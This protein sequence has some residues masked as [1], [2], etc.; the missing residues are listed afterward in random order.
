MA[1]QIGISPRFFETERGRM[2]DDWEIKFWRELIQNSVDADSTTI[3]IRI[4][5]LK[6][7]NGNTV[8]GP[9]MRP[10]CRVIFT[11]NGKGMDY[12][13][14]K[15]V[16]MMLG[17]SSKNSGD[18][19]GGFGRAR[20]LTNFS[21]QRYRIET[22]TWCVEGS[23]SAYEITPLDRTVKGCVQEIDVKG[24]DIETMRHALSRYLSFCQLDVKVLIEDP[25]S[26]EMKPW[27]IW[28]YRRGKTDQLVARN[29]AFADVHLVKGT[30][31]HAGLLI[32]RVNGVAMFEQPHAAKGRVIVEI[33]PDKASPREHK[34]LTLSRDSLHWPYRD[35]L[36]KLQSRLAINKSSALRENKKQSFVIK[37]GADTSGIFSVA[38]NPRKAAKPRGEQE[39]LVADGLSYSLD[40]YEAVTASNEGPA[41]AALK[42]V[43]STTLNTGSDT[44]P[45]GQSNS[46]LGTA[47]GDTPA[48]GASDVK[49]RDAAQGQSPD[50]WRTGELDIVIPRYDIPEP[51]DIDF[52]GESQAEEDACSQ[53]EGEVTVDRDATANGQVSSSSRGSGSSGAEDE[54]RGSGDVRAVGGSWA[55]AQVVRDDQDLSLEPDSVESGSAET[56]SDAA[57]P[58]TTRT[59]RAMRQP[60]P[61]NSALSFDL[62]INVDNPNPKIRRAMARFDPRRWSQPGG[63]LGGGHAAKLLTCWNV[64]VHHSAQAML[65]AIGGGALRYGVGLNFGGSAEALHHITEDGV[66]VYFITP[67]DHTGR[68]AYRTSDRMDRKRMIA[69][70]KHEMAHTLVKYHDE[71]YATLLTMIDA[72]FDER[73]AYRDMDEGLKQLR[74]QTE[75][76]EK[77]I[78]RQQLYA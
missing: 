23:G 34:I 37:G 66:H 2:Y 75:K 73:E 26:G 33:H 53:E 9:D 74:I 61:K 39:K 25:E 50:G 8:F 56:G 68:L 7:E 47:E 38:V 6:D 12:D 51:R 15:N 10:A 78:G 41:I 3:A 44:S 69:D 71:D 14:I 5:Q 16:Y 4:I 21:Q 35:A 60:L 62:F 13:T 46:R 65:R 28:A 70:A 24:A 54:K 17:E 64:A 27:T 49:T 32:V 67:V 72:C 43:P 31:Q 52:T 20:I 29:E 58:P 19:I 36:Y 18:S 45:A 1:E 48:S 76:L 63:N 59:V 77:A 40:K 22:Q 57:P 11:D 55:G 42:P 30:D